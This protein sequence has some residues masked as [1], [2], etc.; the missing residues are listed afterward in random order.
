MVVGGE[1]GGVGGPTSPVRTCQEGIISD[2]FVACACKRV[3]P[4]YLV[5]RP[6]EKER[7]LSWQLRKAHLATMS[8]PCHDSRGRPMQTAIVAGPERLCL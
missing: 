3:E 6:G 4:I 7:A 1:W 8:V 5:F 2:V